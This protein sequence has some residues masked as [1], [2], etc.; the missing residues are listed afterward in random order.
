MNRVVLLPCQIFLN[1]LN[2]TKR[3][4][5]QVTVI[6]KI[7]F[8]LE[9]ISVKSPSTISFARFVKVNIFLSAACG[10]LA[11]ILELYRSAYR[12]LNRIFLVRLSCHLF[13]DVLCHPM[14]I[15]RTC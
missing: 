6:I 13:L 1:S 3:K 8:G 2:S 15:Q 5:P 10:Q 9:I 14:R 7:N 12:P 4:V 11:M